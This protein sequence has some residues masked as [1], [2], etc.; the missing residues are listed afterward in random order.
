[1]ILSSSHLTGKPCA[2]LGGLE[3]RTAIHRTQNQKSIKYVLKL[4]SQYRMQISTWMNWFSIQFRPQV[5]Q[6]GGWWTTIPK[7]LQAHNTI[8]EL[9]TSVTLYIKLF[10]PLRPSLDEIQQKKKKKAV[11]IFLKNITKEIQIF[12]SYA[13]IVYEFSACK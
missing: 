11:N 13:H 4:Q 7:C 6:F 9:E 8:Q 2:S 12:K 3:S 10:N 1:M 5:N